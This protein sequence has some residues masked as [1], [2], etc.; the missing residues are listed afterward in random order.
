MFSPS[1]GGSRGSGGD[2]G[3]RKKKPPTGEAFPAGITNDP[4]PVVF[5]QGTLI[6]LI[7][8]TLGPLLLTLL[9]AI[10]AFFFFYHKT[11]SHLI[12]TEVHLAQGERSKLETKVEAS[13]QRAETR[14]VIKS[15]ID[16][17]C[18]EIRVEQKEQIQELGRELKSEQK[19]QFTKILSEI[20]SRHD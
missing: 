11:N 19:K 15:H 8:W 9:G 16:V 6:K 2:G 13:R 12:N 4:V 17:K 7:S 20:K 5:T 10:S 3:V 14:R 18:R 1:N